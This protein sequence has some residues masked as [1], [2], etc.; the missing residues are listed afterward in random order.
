MPGPREAF[1][2]RRQQR[3]D[4]QVLDD[5]AL[6]GHATVADQYLL[7]VLLIAQRRGNTPH[8]QLRIPAPQAR[9]GQL[10]LHAALVAD[11]L[12]PFVHHHHLQCRQGDLSVGTGQQQRQAFRG[13]DQGRGQPPTLPGAF[14]A[15]G[16]AG[17]QADRPRN[18]QL[19]QWRLKGPG[20]IGGQGAHGRDPQDTQRFGRRFA[21]AGFVVS[22]ERI[23]FGEAVDRGEPYGVG[24]ARA[25][26]GMQQT[27]LAILHR[28]P[29]L[30]LERKGLP[31]SG[32]K[33]SSSE[34]GRSAHPF[35]CALSG[36][37][38][39]TAEKG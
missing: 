22:G 7:R 37:K 29:D 19:C 26:A 35:E 33:P 32:E 16:I 25:G 14:A 18:V 6:H 15:A 20:G 28:R 1:D 21:F 17:A 12:V 11:Q 34:I 10:Q 13:G 4:L 3:I 8:D 27:G 36:V 5:F 39:E 9:Q 23:G 38:S 2:G 30:F 31:A 24:L